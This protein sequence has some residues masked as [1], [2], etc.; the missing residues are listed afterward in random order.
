MIVHADIT[1]C[2]EAE[3]LMYDYAFHDSLTM[4]ANR[5]LLQERLDM[6]I[7]SSKRSGSYGVLLVIDLDNFKPLND[8]YGHEVGDLLLKHVASR[9]KACTRQV[10]TVARIGGDE[11]VVVLG[12]LSASATQS[13]QRAM[14]IAE[15][16]RAC[17]AEP[18]TCRCVKGKANFSFRIIV[19]PVSADHFFR[20]A[21]TTRWKYFAMPTP[22]C[23]WPRSRAAMPSALR[24]SIDEHRRGWQ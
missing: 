5:R 17:L 21:H 13:R 12:E 19:R 8:Q 22:P 24:S 2:K 11:F 9:L 23:T 10:D 3:A 6:T 4:L 16:I 1:A 7:A 14:K 18:Y 20:Q 15:K